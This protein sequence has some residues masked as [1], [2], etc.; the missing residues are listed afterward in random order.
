MN[1]GRAT[2]TASTRTSS[3]DAMTHKGNLVQSIYQLC[4][5][6]SA[7]EPSPRVIVSRP[8]TMTPPVEFGPFPGLIGATEGCLLQ[9]LT[10]RT[11]DDSG[12]FRLESTSLG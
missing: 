12:P 5:I 6:T 2:S 11:I 1:Y 4:A 9:R 8:A 7:N 3:A 10:A